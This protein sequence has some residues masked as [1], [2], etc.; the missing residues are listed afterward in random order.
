MIVKIF[1]NAK[2]G[3]D[4]SII[5]SDVWHIKIFTEGGVE[6][7]ISEDHGKLHLSVDAQMIIEPGAANTINISTRRF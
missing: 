5:R 7:Q 4:P 3:L 1:T 2:V 6:L